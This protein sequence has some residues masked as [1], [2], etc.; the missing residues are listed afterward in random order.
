MGHGQR[1]GRAD[2][3][4]HDGAVRYTDNT[5]HERGQQPLISSSV[6]AA[7][8]VLAPQNQRLRLVR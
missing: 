6:P 1:V 3:R 5:L 7:K 8:V 2:G 4:S